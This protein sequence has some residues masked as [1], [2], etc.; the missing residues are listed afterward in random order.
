[1]SELA[2]Y[3]RRRRRRDRT[4]THSDA[5]LSSIPSRHKRPFDEINQSYSHGR[6][7][8]A[9]SATTS[10]NNIGNENVD[11]SMMIIDEDDEGC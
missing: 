8:R 7:R 11:C 2:K 9:L 10:S 3:S 6:K 1:M 5:V 4:K